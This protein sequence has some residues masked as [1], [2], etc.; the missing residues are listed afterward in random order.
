MTIS[1]PSPTADP[2]SRP[3]LTPS[4]TIEHRVAYEDLVGEQQEV[5]HAREATMVVGG[6]AGVGKTTTALWAARMEL[7]RPDTPPGTRVLFLTFSRTAV[8]QILARSR[9]VLAGITDRVEILTFHGLAFRL[10]CGFGR[11]AGHPAIPTLRGE[12][13]RKLALADADGALTYDDLLPLA[14]DLL[15][16]NSPVR[17]LW[18]SRWSLVVCDEFQD[19]DSDQWRLLELLGDRARLLLLADP[20]R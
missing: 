20:T 2:P 16:E 15:A 13:E 1:A 19:T 3:S 12:S 5:L 7:T 11:Y 6:G 9:A 18:L 10:A 17:D 4:P 8:A 14:L